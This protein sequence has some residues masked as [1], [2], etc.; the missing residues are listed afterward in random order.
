M[1]HGTSKAQ[2]AKCGAKSEDK[3]QVAKCLS[4]RYSCVG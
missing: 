3:A 2:V 4:K 1:C